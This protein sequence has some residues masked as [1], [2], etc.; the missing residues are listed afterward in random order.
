MLKAFLIFLL[1]IVIVLISIMLGAMN[2]QLVTI[3]YFVARSELKLSVLMAIVMLIGVALSSI[4]FSLFWLRLKLRIRALER[5]QKSH[6][7]TSQ[8]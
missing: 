5:K 2:D 3:N 6:N 7:Q 1:A 8:V 4:V